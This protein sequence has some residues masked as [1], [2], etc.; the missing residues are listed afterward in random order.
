MD[1]EGDTLTLRWDA[2]TINGNNI[3]LYTV[4]VLLENEQVY[5]T[6]ASGTSFSVSRNDIQEAGDIVRTR[7]TQYTVVVVARNERGDS[8]ETSQTFTVPAGGSS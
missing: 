2:P 8:V 1:I 7:D 4:E 6:M 3:V 5:S